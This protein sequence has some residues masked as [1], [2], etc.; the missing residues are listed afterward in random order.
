MFEVSKLKNYQ[1][2]NTPSHPFSKMNENEI[3]EYFVK[4][5]KQIHD[6]FNK[7]NSL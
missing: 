4:L 3:E 5:T 2:L 6:I 1:A 7:E